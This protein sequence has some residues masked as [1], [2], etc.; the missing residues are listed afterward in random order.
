MAIDTNTLLALYRKLVITR[1]AEQ[2]WAAM[3]E[4]KEFYL[5]G[6]F[7]TGQEAIGVGI[8]HALA[9][10]DYLLPTHRGLAEYV[11][12]GMTQERIWAEYYT[13][14]AGPARGKG[15]LH[16]SDYGVGLIGLVGS[17]GADYAIA[18]G[19]ALSAKLRGSGQ[20]T[21]LCFGEGTSSQADFGSALNA[22]ALWKL[23]LIFAM[24]NNEWCELSHYSGHVCTVDVAPRAEG[25]GIPWEIAD[26]NDVVTVYETAGRAVEEVRAGGGP[27]FLEFKTYRTGPHWSGDDG[28]YM[29]EEDVC[30]WQ[31]RDPIIVCGQHLLDVGAVGADD[32]TR[33]KDE[34]HAEVAA[35]IAAA[36]ALPDTTYDQMLAG[37]FSGSSTNE[38]GNA[39]VPATG[40]GR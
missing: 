12:K 10:S 2:I 21:V 19:T 25:Y 36:Q 4:R 7:G 37:V 14:P 13:K 11:G 26:G 6:H 8:G 29:C 33:I 18:V 40:E 3:L 28:S 35:A 30:R 9:P 39:G 17:L 15:G 38:G 34:I 31:E 20:V 24:T 5:M 1:E 22:A 23:P 16:L 32:L 27:R